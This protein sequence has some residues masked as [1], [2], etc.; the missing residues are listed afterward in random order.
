M[1]RVDFIRH[2]ATDLGDALLGRSDPPLSDVGRQAVARQL[3]GRTWA[4]IV[5]SPLSRAK[6]SADIAAD[7]CGLEPEIDPAWREIDFG[8][9]DGQPRS[10][11]A[12]DARFGAF[13]ANPDAN[14]PPN[15]EPMENVRA[16]VEAALLRLAV[17]DTGTI[18]VVAHGGSIRMALSVLL[19]LPLDRLWSIRIDAATR[20]TVEMGRDPK[21]GLWGE[22]IEIAQPGWERAA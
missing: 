5:A 15:G 13:R 10:V 19:A 1:T 22:I 14:P 12:A 6:Q 21:H 18:L 7:A 16:R 9:W 20:I 8:D 11:L 3:A 2:G 17:R 4:A